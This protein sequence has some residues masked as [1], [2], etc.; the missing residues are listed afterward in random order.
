[1][2]DSTKG[3]ERELSGLWI[4]R[5]NDCVFEEVTIITKNSPHGIPLKLDEGKANHPT[6]INKLI[7]DTPYKDPMVLDNV[8]TNVLVKRLETTD[9]N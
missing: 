4:N 3:E 6:F 1:M 9:G 5:C 7:F 8:L 2:Q